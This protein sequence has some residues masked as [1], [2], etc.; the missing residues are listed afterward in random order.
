MIMVTG[1]NIL[2][3]QSLN[4]SYERQLIFALYRQLYPTI[5]Q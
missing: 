4:E 2:K 3:A 5:Y 1:S